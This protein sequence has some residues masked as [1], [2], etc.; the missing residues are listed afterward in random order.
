M[1]EDT[2]VPDCVVVSVVLASTAPLAFTTLVISIWKLPA[3][4]L[5][6]FETVRQ[7]GRT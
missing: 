7:G 1:G 6:T 2:A 5:L 4:G 3:V